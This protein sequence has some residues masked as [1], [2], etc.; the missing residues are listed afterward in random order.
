MATSIDEFV[1]KQPGDKWEIVLTVRELAEEAIPF[2]VA[3]SVA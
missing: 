2:D 1:A 3:E